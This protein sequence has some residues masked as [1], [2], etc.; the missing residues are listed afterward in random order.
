M[1]S[2]ALALLLQWTSMGS[3]QP[4]V[5]FDGIFMSCPDEDSYT[6]RAFEYVVGKQTVWALH[7][8]P[9]DEFALFAGAVPDDHVD[10]ADARNRLAPA[11]HY[12][13]LQTA[14]GGRSWSALGAHVNIVQIPGSH[15]DC[16]YF[17]I[18]VEQEARPIWA[19]RP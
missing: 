2:V 5:V 19:A 9:R 13:D 15:E 11:Y 16:Y 17:A 14:V 12:G 8:G 7:M 3:H 1:T 6:E 10:H 18:K 4:R